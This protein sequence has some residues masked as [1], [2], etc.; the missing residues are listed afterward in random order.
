MLEHLKD[1][2]G[3]LSFI[4][5][6][7][8]DGG[9]CVIMIPVIDSWEQAVFKETSAWISAP[10]HLSLYSEKTMRSLAENNNFKIGKVENDWYT[11]SI[12]SFSIFENLERYFGIC[13]PLQLRKIAAILIFP[14]AWPAIILS[15][16]FKKSALKTF[17]LTHA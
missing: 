8:K 3:M 16:I 17:Y 1:P 7:L 13:M 11:P 2:A 14:L 6:K 5:K 10:Y 9:T 12:F 4:S 15:A